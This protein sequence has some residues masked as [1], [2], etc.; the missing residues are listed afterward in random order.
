PAGHEVVVYEASPYPG[1]DPIARRL[2]LER[3]TAADVTA[4]STLYVPPLEQPPHAG[5]GDHVPLLLE[6]AA[7]LLGR[8]AGLL[9]APGGRQDDRQVLEHTRAELAAVASRH[10]R[11]RLARQ[12]LRLCVLAA[13]GVDDGQRAARDR[14]R[15]DVV[16][17]RVGA[18]LQEVGLGLPVAALPDERLRQEG[19]DAGPVAALAHRVEQLEPAAK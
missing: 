12:R 10:E 7:S 15:P 11:D 13:R 5:G 4:L 16:R 18:R 3:L 2:P 8:G 1:I 14:L 19:G 9:G 6:R 17:P